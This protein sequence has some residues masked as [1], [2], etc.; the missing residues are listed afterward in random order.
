MREDYHFRPSELPENIQN[1]IVRTDT[2]TFLGN[3]FKY[4]I[5]D[6]SANP[7]VK[8]FSGMPGGNNLYVS[9]GILDEPLLTL[10][11]PNDLLRVTLQ[12]LILC[13][14]REDFAF[15]IRSCVDAEKYL[16]QPDSGKTPYGIE[17]PYATQVLS[18]RCR[19]FEQ[20]CTA[21]KND[22]S[23]DLD[24]LQETEETL[25]F[26]SAEKPFSA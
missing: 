6:P 1:K 25:Y 9:Q 16:L 11:N 26:L 5:V 4:A 15:N 21:L 20:L 13:K 7:A 10:N 12:H 22:R 2:I 24:C 19:M 18:F 3:T 17:F 23:T 14:R 8:H